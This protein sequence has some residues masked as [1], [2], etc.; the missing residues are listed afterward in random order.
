VEGHDAA[1][2][3]VVPLHERVTG[4]LIAAAEQMPESD[5]SYRPSDEV[6]TFGQVVG[7][8]ANTQYMFCGTISGGE[9]DPP[10]NFEMRTSKAGLVDALKMAFAQCDA[11][12]ALNDAQA[13]QELEFFGNTGTKLWGLT[14]HIA[15]NWEHYGTLATYMRATGHVPPSSQGGI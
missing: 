10:E 12:Y 5:Y 8:L 11:A 7:H 3:S 9:S 6:R 1:V 2:Q 4:Y 15:H 13:M 14:F